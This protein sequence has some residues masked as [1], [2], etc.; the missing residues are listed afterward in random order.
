[1]PDRRLSTAGSGSGTFDEDDL[2]LARAQPDYHFCGWSA[3]IRIFRRDD[4]LLLAE[5][6]V[7]PA[8]AREV[9]LLDERFGSDARVARQVSA[10]SSCAP[11]TPRT[12]LASSP[13]CTRGATR[14]GGRSVPAPT[15]DTRI[16]LTDHGLRGRLGPEAGIAVVRGTC[17]GH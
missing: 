14:D 5:K 8:Y 17:A 4:A 6:Y 13:A 1:M 2:R 15:A 7:Y 12:W 11:S 9:A 16:D 10:S 3:A